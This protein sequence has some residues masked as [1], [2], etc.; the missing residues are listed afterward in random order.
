MSLA[1]TRGSYPGTT[2]TWQEDYGD[3][4]LA[5]DGYIYDSNK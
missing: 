2:F 4:Y 5:D 3:V 1:F